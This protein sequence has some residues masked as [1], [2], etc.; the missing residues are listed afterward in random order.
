M[1]FSH[2]GFR[3]DVP[4]KGRWPEGP[5][6]CVNARGGQKGS[7]VAIC[8]EKN[9]TAHSAPGNPPASRDHLWGG[10][11]RGRQ[12]VGSRPWSKPIAS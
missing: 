1:S 2:P 10:W 11:A 8:K 3:L 5:T 7:R 4:T 12:P 9:T 6:C